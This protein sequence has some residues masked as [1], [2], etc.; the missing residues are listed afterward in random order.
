MYG[1][2]DK[3]PEM[4]PIAYLANVKLLYESGTGTHTPANGLHR[5]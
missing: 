3:V 2:Y 4:V 1:T 5:E